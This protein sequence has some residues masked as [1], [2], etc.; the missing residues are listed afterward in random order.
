MLHLNLIVIT[1]EIICVSGG[2]NIK[3]TF[4][5]SRATYYSPGRREYGS[6]SEWNKICLGKD[7]IGDGICDHNNLSDK[8]DYDKGD[9]CQQSSIGDG[10]C[11]N[12]NNFASCGNFDGGDCPQ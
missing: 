8:C 12:R 5:G 6:F 3:I 4:F 11:D 2:S 7:S 9:C 10:N 1:P